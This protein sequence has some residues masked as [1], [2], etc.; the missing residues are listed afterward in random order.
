MTEEIRPRRTVSDT[1]QEEEIQGT[2]EADNTASDEAKKDPG[3]DATDPTGRY[4]IPTTEDIASGNFAD[5]FGAT[6]E[7]RRER[8]TEAQQ[9]G[10]QGSGT[11]GSSSAG[12]AGAAAS[13]G[14]GHQSADEVAESIRNRTFGESS[15]GDP[16]AS[17][18]DQETEQDYTF[19]GSDAVDKAAGHS[20]TSMDDLAAAADDA[21]EGPGLP[22]K[23]GIS[24]Q[25]VGGA[26]Y[27]AG[28]YSE[29]E[30]LKGPG[31]KVNPDDYGLVGEIA[32]G[33]ARGIT[34]GQGAGET[35]R[36][37]R[38][39]MEEIDSLGGG[40]Q[41]A[42]GEQPAGGTQPAGGEQSAGGGQT[43]K[44]YE[45]PD[46]T[47]TTVVKDA[48]GTTTVMKGDTITTAKPD[49]TVTE[50]NTTTGET[51]TYNVKDPGSEGGM[52]R[53]EMAEAMER[54]A[55]YDWMMQ[56]AT[57][58]GPSGGEEVNPTREGGAEFGASIDQYS[59]TQDRMY[60]LVGN[61][62]PEGDVSS[63]RAA[64]GTPP[65]GGDQGGYTDPSD[66][67]LSDRQMGQTEDEA[68]AL[69]SDVHET[70]AAA[71]LIEQQPADEQDDSTTPHWTY[72]NRSADVTRNL[73]ASRQAADGGAEG[74]E[75]SVSAEEEPKKA[76][77]FAEVE[78]E[79][80]WDP[81][82]AAPPKGWV[83]I[84][85]PNAGGEA[86]ADAAAG[87]YATDPTAEDPAAA[88]PYTADPAATDPYATDPYATDPAAQ[89][90]ATDPYATDP[91]A[92]DPYATDPAE[93]PSV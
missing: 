84:T 37:I 43:I 19:G 72:A 5:P 46:G 3:K 29:A 25:R 89:D 16:M 71:G 91:A 40:T 28:N 59:F 65:L 38:Q 51:T 42:G 23:E 63:G 76:G 47:A 7:S 70:G 14:A 33:A 35:N 36:Q 13:Q 15:S 66:D 82:D 45:N 74:D 90:P 4:G 1:E 77:E 50:R 34:P 11:T 92:D 85:D 2:Q 24:D 22:G 54:K 56:N 9:G 39:T 75:R 44:S 80:P 6:E 55:Q 20:L 21:A 8:Y 69:E 58:R 62:G 68:D 57:G 83:T 30:G 49:G 73:N 12:V 41:P 52:T 53:E 87:P 31:H 18:L 88:D 64:P 60:D 67:A 79:D 78:K 81:S 93:D 61:P 32:K 17:P 26:G 86:P 10:P 27:G 48:D